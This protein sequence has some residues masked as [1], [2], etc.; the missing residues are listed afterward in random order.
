MEIDNPKCKSCGKTSPCNCKA[1]RVPA[2]WCVPIHAWNALVDEKMALVKQVE[3]LKAQ[4]K[5]HREVGDEAEQE[6][7]SLQTDAEQIKLIAEFATGEM[8]WNEWNGVEY[9]KSLPEFIKSEFEKME[10]KIDDLRWAAMGED[11]QCSNSM[12]LIVIVYFVNLRIG[13]TF[14]F[15]FHI[16]YIVVVVG[17]TGVGEQIDE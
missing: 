3:L 6:V 9:E 10:N 1:I 5:V 7:L 16:E 17:C 15:L 8:G 11:L 12:N 13:G 4:L 2:E 14:T